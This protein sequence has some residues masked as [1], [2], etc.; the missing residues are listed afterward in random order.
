MKVRFFTSLEDFYSCYGK[1]PRANW[2]FF[3]KERKD[4]SQMW[5]YCLGTPE[6]IEQIKRKSTIQTNQ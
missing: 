1:M 2:V 4:G 5:F 3:S 6:A